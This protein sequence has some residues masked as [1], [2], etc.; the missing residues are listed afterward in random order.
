[1]YN[2]LHSDSTVVISES[3]TGANDDDDN[4]RKKNGTIYDNDR[5]EK[6]RRV[7]N[8]DINN[9][10]KNHTNHKKGQ[11]QKHIRKISSNVCF[12]LFTHPSPLP[13]YSFPSLLSS[14]LTVPFP[15]PMLNPSTLP[16]YPFLSPL[17]TSPHLFPFPFPSPINPFPCT[18]L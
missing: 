9:L 8:S 18:F 3:R 4:V 16:S 14:L 15:L 6:D 5:F 12:L 1:M 2:F 17:T 7:L 10:D 13:S 11:R